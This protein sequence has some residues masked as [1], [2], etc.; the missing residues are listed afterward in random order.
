MPAQRRLWITKFRGTYQADAGGTI[1][2]DSQ[3]GKGTSV[4]IEIPDNFNS[5]MPY[6]LPMGY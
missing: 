1:I 3:P 4:L 5:L 2:I 6:Q